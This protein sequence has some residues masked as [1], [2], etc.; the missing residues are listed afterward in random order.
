MAIGVS[1]LFH[2]KLMITSCVVYVVRCLFQGTTNVK[3]TLLKDGHSFT[4]HILDPQTSANT[5]DGGNEADKDQ[6][7]GSNSEMQNA[8]LPTDGKS[9]NCQVLLQIF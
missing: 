5:K 6:K 4:V 3:A 1:F 9:L 2:F 8:Q 7:H